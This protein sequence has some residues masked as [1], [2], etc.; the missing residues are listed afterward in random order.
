[1][2]G[3]L[4]LNISLLLALGICH[5]FL[6]HYWRPGS[7]RY[8]IA[9]GI[10]FGGTAIAGMLFPFHYAPGVIFDG[11]SFVA[12]MAGLFGGPVTATFVVI[13]GGAYRLSLGGAGAFTG[14]GVLTTS[15]ALGVA[16][17]YWSQGRP[18]RIQPLYLYLF[19][20]IVHLCMLLWMLTLPWPLAGEV[21]SKIWAPVMV[22][23]P[24]GTVLLGMFLQ[25]QI[26]GRHALIALKESENLFRSAFEESVAGMCFISLEGRYLKVNRSLCTML[27]YSEEELLGRHFAE[28]SHPDDVAVSREGARGL[29]ENRFESFRL[30]KRYLHKNGQVVWVTLSTFLLRNAGGDPLYYVTHIQDI[31]DRK[32]AE[33][34]VKQ[35]ELRYRELFQNMSDGVTVYEA[36]GDA[37]DFI[38]REINPSGEKICKVERSDVIGRSVLE[39][40]PGVREMGLFGVFREVWRTGTPRSHPTT[41][42]RDHRFFFWVENYVCK[43]PTGEIV[44]IFEDVTRRKQAEDENRDLARFPSEN[45]NPVLRVTPG[46]VVLYANDAGQ[47]LLESLNGALNEPLPEPIRQWIVEALRA[48]GQ[49]IR[50]IQSGDRWFLLDIVPITQGPYINVY[51]RDITDL[52]KLE[53]QLVQAQK[54]EAIGRLAGGVAHDFNNLLMVILNYSDLACQRLDKTDPLRGDMVEIRKAG[55]RAASLTR[56]LL[57]FSRKQVLDPKILNLNSLVADLDKMLR[58]LIGEDIDL[59]AVTDPDLGPVKADP[60]QIEQVIVN[61][62]VNARDA[63]PE[64]GKLTIETANA[65]L[66]DGYAVNHSQVVPGRYVMLAVSDTGI[67]MDAETR[68]HV[69]EPF[70]TTKEKGKGTGLGLSTVYGIVKQSGGYVWVYSEPG[71][72]TAVKVYLPR[73]RESN[74]SA[75]VET[76]P[77]NLS[78]SETILV[79]E[80]DAGVRQL[81]L[82]I[83]KSRGYTT[84]EALNATEAFSI[85]EQQKNTIH[86]LLTD[87]IMPRMSGR[88]LAERLK[89]LHPDMKV[90]Y[91]SG[92]TDNAIVHHGVL[93]PGVAF[94]QKPFKPDAL[95]RKVRQVLGAPLRDQ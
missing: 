27:G 65:D 12:S 22:I 67:G 54:M 49:S 42:Y 84:L 74:E 64:G 62:A 93:D 11:R 16:Y 50:E 3:S 47:S 15:A 1:M 24:I 85:C 7:M 6:L 71:T 52:K 92:Y 60:G 23:F 8:R 19:G 78:G 2:A 17:H 63:M 41:I 80:D 91:M 46:G 38:I 13:I 57:A 28:I 36:I 39:V 30:E 61:L 4:I 94:L 25:D 88:Q 31:T 45:P 87:V 70:F 73:V 40:F 44:A 35:S 95:L 48:G 90:L 21:I 83:L 37:E 76:E 34:A 82:H 9:C 75:K 69:F 77:V 20:G 59:V 56:Q 89:P 53:E 32:S 29:R 86:L 33:A 10:L 5:F 58:R 43:L 18:S 55:E 79:V 68:S 26:E 66:N 51:G 14:I 81:V 72:G